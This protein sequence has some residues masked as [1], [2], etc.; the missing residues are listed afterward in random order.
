MIMD[1]KIMTYMTHA[2]GIVNGSGLS[3]KH[4]EN[5]CQGNT[6]LVIC[7]IFLPVVH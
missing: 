3:M 4:I 6:T 1:P 2:I 5:S 7:L